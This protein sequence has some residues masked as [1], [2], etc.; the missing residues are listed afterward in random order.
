MKPIDATIRALEG[1]KRTANNGQNYWLGREICPLLGY[2][3]WGKFE[4]VIRRAALACK[5]TG[6]VVK[7][8][9]AQTGKMI[10]V[11]KGAKVK[12]GDFFLS[13]YACYLIAMNGDTAKPQVATAQTYFAVQT[14]RQELNDELMLDQHRILL[15]DRL[16]DATKDLHMAAKQSG[17]QSYGLFYDAGYRGLYDMQLDEVKARKKLLPTDDLFDHAGRSELAAHFFRATQ[18]EECLRREKV[19]NE[20]IAKQV[21]FDVGRRVRKTI[22]M[23]GNVVPEDLP[24]EPHI[25]TIREKFRVRASLGHEDKGRTLIENAESETSTTTSD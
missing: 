22:Q 5:Q 17:V 3:E 11:G 18:T 25:K 4:K 1:C 7:N 20:K 10:E 8:H 9:F 24:A 13:R 6:V 16:T 15:R 14:R 2:G 12:R 19:S 23:N 21:H